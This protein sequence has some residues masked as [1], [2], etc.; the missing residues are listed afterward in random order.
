MLKV[1][2]IKPAENHLVKIG[3]S[4]TVWNFATRW[5]QCIYIDN[6]FSSNLWIAKYDTH[7]RVLTFQ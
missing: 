4:R 7:H 5:P 2:M 3:K 6:A 1:F